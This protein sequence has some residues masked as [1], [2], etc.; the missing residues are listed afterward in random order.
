M[1][2]AQQYLPGN[3]Q[4]AQTAE[5]LTAVVC[6][7]SSPAG[8]VVEIKDY[9]SPDEAWFRLGTTPLD[10]IRIPKGY[11]RWRISKQGVGEY[12]G[13]PLTEDAMD[14]ELDSAAS[15]PEGMVRVL[16]GEGGDYIDFIGWFGPHNLPPFYIDRFE[17]TNR[18]S[19]DFVNKDSNL[20]HD[21]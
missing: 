9:L 16:G 1:Q 10:K 13:A 18:Q 20:I 4:L 7:R 21:F 2:T 17:G 14:F 8:A 5:D 6:I 3:P 15:A 11:F 12:I 19:Q